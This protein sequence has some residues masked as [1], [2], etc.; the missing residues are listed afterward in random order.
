[1]KR[2]LGSGNREILGLAVPALGA[3]AID[4]L[5]TLV[6]TAFVARL[7]TVELAALG[8]DTAL[9]SFAFFAFNFL[10][11][12]VT[13]VVAR[14]L[15]RG[16]VEEARRWIGDALVLAVGLGILVTVILE[17]AAPMLVEL[18]GAEDEL[19]GPAVTYLRIRGLAAPAVLVVTAG[20]GAFRGH[21]DTRTPLLVALGVNL[22]NVVLDPLLIF[23]FGWGLAGAA[24]ATA[25]AQYAGAIWFLRLIMNRDMAARPRGL[26]ESLPS[27]LDL[28]RNG[29]LLTARTGLLLFALTFAA[30]TATRLGPQQIAAH[31]L[32]GQVFLLAALL[33]DSFAIAAQAMVGET[34]AR[35]DLDALSRLNRRLLGWGL[36]AGLIL[37]AGIWVGRHGLELLSS[38]ETV[39][40]LAVHASGV[41]ALIEPIAA[42]VFVADGI[43]LG[44]L[45]LGTMVVSTGA[46]AAVA[47]T[48]MAVSPLG[49]SVDGIWWAIAVMLVVRGVVFLA[50]Y[51]RAAVTAVRS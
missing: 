13:P 23:T 16:A 5:L 14:A 47:V 49:E 38:D 26:R 28:G 33:A 12:V 31:Q 46:G 29:V 22:I 48:L 17:L 41:V 11:Y 1:M 30:S 7:G 15:G 51:R 40:G 25:F 45:A 20:H 10:A 32:V 42:L 39:A 50:G 35:G 24:V 21:K 37:M 27:L 43:F 4:P 18:M 2:G 19:A 6:D 9:F 34:G 8:V 44:M 36:V 3:L